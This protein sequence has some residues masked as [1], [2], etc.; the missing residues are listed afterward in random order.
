M[1]GAAPG[2]KERFQRFQLLYHMHLMENYEH[3][4]LGGFHIEEQVPPL[5]HTH[6]H[7]YAYTHTH[8]HIHTHPSRPS[9]M[10]RSVLQLP[11]PH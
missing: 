10:A 4:L 6:T 3:I 11:L 1:L 7:A 5:T 8:T 9:S 2:I